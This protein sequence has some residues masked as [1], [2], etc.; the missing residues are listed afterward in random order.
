MSAY[1]RKAER[2]KGIA[3]VEAAAVDLRRL[4]LDALADHIV[5]VTKAYAMR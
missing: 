4:G 2:V 1:P 3:V 5:R